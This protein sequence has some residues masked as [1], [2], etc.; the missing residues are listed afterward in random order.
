MDTV[1]ERIKQPAP[2]P[3][4]ELLVHE[5]APNLEGEEELLR[6]IAVAGMGVSDYRESVEKLSGF[7]SARH[8]KAT[9]A[10]ARFYLGQAYYFR[11][12]YREAMSEFVFSR[13]TYYVETQ[14][15][16]DACLEKLASVKK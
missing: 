14:S 15:W 16:I 13:G 6:V 10:R 12:Q 11:G 2:E 4:F 7:L 1:I 9:E 8:S 3:A 5:E